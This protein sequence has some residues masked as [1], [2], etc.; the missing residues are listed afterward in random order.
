MLLHANIGVLKNLV[1]SLIENTIYMMEYFIRSSEEFGLI[2]IFQ[3]TQ[4]FFCYMVAS[5]YII[6]GRE[7]LETMCLERDHRPSQRNRNNVSRK[8]PQAF[9]KGTSKLSYILR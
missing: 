2:I 7:S 8:R 3:D 6:G 5:R 4:Q 9:H 1:C